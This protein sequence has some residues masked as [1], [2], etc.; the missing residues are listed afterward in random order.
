MWFKFKKILEP[1]LLILKQILCNIRRSQGRDRTRGLKYVLKG[2]L[3]VFYL[4]STWRTW[5]WGFFPSFQVQVRVSG[6]G[7]SNFK[8]HF[9]TSKPIPGCSV[10]WAESNGANIFQIR[11]F[12]H[13]LRLKTVQKC[14]KAWIVGENV[15]CLLL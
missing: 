11:P 12:Y 10:Q 3:S 13:K 2:Y 4:Y 1:E 14:Q 5:F 7:G 6:S 15:F 8:S 9:D